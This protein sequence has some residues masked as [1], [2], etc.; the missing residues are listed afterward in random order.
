MSALARALATGID[1]RHG[2]T[3]AAL[4]DLPDGWRLTDA[5]GL[6]CGVFDAVIL[7][8]PSPQAETLL[9]PFPEVA[10]DLA[11]VE[12]MPMWTLLLGFDAPTGLPQAIQDFSAPLLAAIPMLAK[13]GQGGAE[14]WT[15]HAQPEWSSANLEI[16]K[17][18]AAEILLLA[19]RDAMKLAT[20]PAYIAVHRWRYARVGRP[21]G[22]PFVAN[23]AGTLLAGGDWALG[24]LATDAV[25]SGEAMAARI[26]KKR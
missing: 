16:E 15:I 24:S 3:V 13:L 7:A 6:D 21:L 22:R 9:A 14:R 17:E 19:F 10:A 23:A 25:A 2:V 12:M 4:T 8:I 18:E 11:T 26:L 1:V 5:D 20:E